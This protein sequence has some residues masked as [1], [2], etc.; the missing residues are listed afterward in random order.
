MTQN[1]NET[2][3][4]RAV[5]FYNRGG[6]YKE[7]K[8]CARWD[9]LVADVH[10]DVPDAVTGDPGCVLHQGVANVDLLM[11]AIDSGPDR[12]VYAGPVLSHHQFEMPGVERKS[13]AEWRQD[14]R[15]GRLPPRPEWTRSYLVAGT[16]PEAAEYYTEE[17]WQARWMAQTDG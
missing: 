13:D 16:N 5:A 7:R 8:D 15:A 9:A 12:M 10:T 1:P 4:N 3:H 14:A 11:V 6:I 17:E 2:P